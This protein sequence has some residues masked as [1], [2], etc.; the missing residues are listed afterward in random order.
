MQALVSIPQRSNSS[1]AMASGA[2]GF[3]ENLTI[4]FFIDQALRIHLPQE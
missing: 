1:G 2:R 4:E 3:S